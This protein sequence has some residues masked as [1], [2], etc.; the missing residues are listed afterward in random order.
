[1]RRNA[2][3]DALIKLST[4]SCE[5][6]PYPF[7]IPAFRLLAGSFLQWQSRSDV[8][9]GRLPRI[10]YGCCFHTPPR[11]WTSRGKE[12]LRVEAADTNTRHC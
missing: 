8:V 7:A 5:E 12:L 2:P 3:T 1:M 11:S 4:A 9:G 6:Q 10:R